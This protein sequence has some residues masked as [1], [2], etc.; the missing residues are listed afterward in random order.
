MQKDRPKDKEKIYRK[1]YRKDKKKK[2]PMENIRMKEKLRK[3]DLNY[4]RN[5]RHRTRLKE[6][7]QT[8]NE[9]DRGK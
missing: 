2:T 6:K 7:R 3:I 1:K 8:L 5:E 4:G 9:K